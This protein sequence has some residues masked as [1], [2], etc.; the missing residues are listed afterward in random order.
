MPMPCYMQ[1]TGT[2]QGKIQGSVAIQGHE[3]TILV[4]AEDSL[5]QIPRNIETGLPMGKRVHQPFKVVKEF[6]K[7]S[8]KIFQALTS[9][10]VLTEVLLEFMRIS[11]AGKEEVYYTIKLQN[12]IVVTLR[13][14][15]PNCFDSETKSLGHM[16]DVSFTYEHITWTFKPDGIEADDNWLAPKA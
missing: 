10:E 1:I 8:P 4:Q 13:K 16:E 9:G 15:V 5:I 3:G 7:S 14:W 6:D 11:P 2:S 12:A